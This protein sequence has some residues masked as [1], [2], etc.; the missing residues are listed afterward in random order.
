MRISKG[1]AVYLAFCLVVAAGGREIYCRFQ[2]QTSYLAVNIQKVRVFHHRIPPHT[3]G[4]MSSQGD[5]DDVYVTNNRGLRGP[6]D[7]AYE[8][9]EGVHRIAVMGDS[10]AFGVGVKAEQTFASGLQ[11]LLDE[12]EPGRY[13]VLNF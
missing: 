3:K 4:T 2:Y 1:Y 6:G 9:K 12:K 13:E 8:K 10:Y 11:R 5:F 7:Y